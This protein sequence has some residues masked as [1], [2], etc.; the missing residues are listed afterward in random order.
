MRPFRHQNGFTLIELIAVL[1]IVAALGATAVAR[2]ANNSVF[3]LQA[4]RDQVVSALLSAQ[5]LAMVQNDAVRFSTQGNQLDILQ[6]GTSVS[7]DGVVYPINLGS[8]QAITG[9]DFDFDRLGQT[10]PATLTLSKSGELVTIS[11]TAT[12]FVQ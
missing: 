2:F 7:I 8:G 3:E 9:A 4:S 11:V 10:Q 12:G 1:V 5:Q 6:D